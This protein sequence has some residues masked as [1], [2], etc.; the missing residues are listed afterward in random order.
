MEYKYV[1]IIVVTILII[2]GIFWANKEHL[3]LSMWPDPSCAGCQSCTF[4]SNGCG[5]LFQSQNRLDSY[6]CPESNGGFVDYNV[7]LCPGC[8]GAENTSEKEDFK[9]EV[10][11]EYVCKPTYNIPE[12]GSTG[13]DIFGRDLPC[14]IPFPPVTPQYKVVAENV[15]A[16]TSMQDFKELID[17]GALVIS[18]KD[19]GVIER[20]FN[21]LVKEYLEQGRQGYADFYYI[22]GPILVMVKVGEYYYYMVDHPIKY[23]PYNM[24]N[25]VNRTDNWN[26]AKTVL[27]MG[28]KLLN[29]N[30]PVFAFAPPGGEYQPIAPVGCIDP[31]LG[32]P[33]GKSSEER[34]ASGCPDGLSCLW[35]S[36]LGS[37][38]WTLKS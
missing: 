27:I 31:P 35:G 38:N 14:P 9:V 15:L 2:V 10:E 1:I 6:P 30:S 5:T 26:I 4:Y 3:S 8:A 34:E 33:S 20:L 32:Y 21:E 11:N 12:S 28:S 17:N 24:P 23:T 13:F 16:T 37:G 36:V 19:N 22:E 7:K 29:Q 25:Y 18:A